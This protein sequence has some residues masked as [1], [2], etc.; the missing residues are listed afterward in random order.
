MR[1]VPIRPSGA[2]RFSMKIKDEPEL[3]HV[4][5]HVLR[6]V[7]FLGM[8]CEALAEGEEAQAI[9]YTQTA[10]YECSS[11]EGLVTFEGDED[12]VCYLNHK[13]T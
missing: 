6:A 4:L 10:R 12:F 11:I 7:Q 3:Q 13:H 1:V 9:T 2:G 5:A 8:A